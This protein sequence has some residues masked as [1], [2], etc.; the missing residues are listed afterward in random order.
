MSAMKTYRKCGIEVAVTDDGFI[1]ELNDKYYALSPLAYIV[2][3][4]S[5]G[6]TPLQVIAENISENSGVKYEDVVDVV[7]AVALELEKHGL[8][9]PV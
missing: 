5:D 8:L 3:A 1:V 9:E 6:E 2:W 4:M 7:I